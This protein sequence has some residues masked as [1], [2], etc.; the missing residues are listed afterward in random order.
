MRGIFQLLWV[1]ATCSAFLAQAA[2]IAQHV[3]EPRTALVIGNAAYAQSPLANPVNDAS[4]MAQALRGAGFNVILKTDADQRGM[5][6]AVRTFGD[7]LKRSGGVGLF[8]Y[9]GHGAQLS[10]ENYILPVGDAIRSEAD[11]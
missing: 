10:G 11:L 5:K 3:A 2:A 9:A 1:A 6:D 4:D 7:A 8:F